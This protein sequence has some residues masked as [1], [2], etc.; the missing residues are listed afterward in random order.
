MNPRK[1]LTGTVVAAAAFAFVTAL[2]LAAQAQTSAQ[3]V[4]LV[5]DFGNGQKKVYSDIPWRKGE[6]VLDV[7][8]YARTKL[9]GV[10]FHCP[11]DFACNGPSK[12]AYLEDIDGVA[13]QGEGP[14]KRNW[15]YQVNKTFIQKSF[16]I[17]TV[18]AKDTVLW[19]FALND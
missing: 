3:T 17:E 11:A 12:M 4:S 15:L 2:S 6:T 18:N 9:H 13:N 19:M 10:T 7:M 14:G 5:V 1:M 16:A 8:N